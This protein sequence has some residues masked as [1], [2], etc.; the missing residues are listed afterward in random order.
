MKVP[1]RRRRNP[2]APGSLATPS[3]DR[4]SNKDSRMSV[5]KSALLKGAI[6]AAAG[7]FVVSTAA[8][9]DVVCNRWH[10]CWHVQNRF[11]DY[12]ANVGVTFHDDTWASAGAPPWLALADRPR[13]PWLLSQRHLD[14]L[15]TPDPQTPLT[16]S[17]G[18]RPR[19]V[20]RPRP[21]RRKECQHAWLGHF[22]QRVVALICG[23]LGFFALAGLT[24]SIAKLLFLVF[25][26]LLIISFFIRALRGGSVV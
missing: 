19:R 6:I 21:A 9:A 15:L 8:S 7:A 22:L 25:V 13:R 26:I 20:R 4:H 12:P 5:L 1:S 11:N 18:R 16:W 23:A 10:D 14:R 17:A 24:A 2:A 3:G